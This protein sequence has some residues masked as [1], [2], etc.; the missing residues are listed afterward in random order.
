MPGYRAQAETPP[1]APIL[2]AVIQTGLE[3]AAG[4]DFVV[5]HNTTDQPVDVTGYKLQYRAATATGAAAWTTKRTIACV[6]AVV[7]C[8]VHL[9]P[10]TNLVLA[11]YDIPGIERHPL[12]SGFSDVGGQVRLV[13]PGA[14]VGQVEVLD[15]VGYGNAAESEGSPAAAPPVGQ[16]IARKQ[17]AEYA[18]V[19]TQNNINDF[20][21]G[22]YTVA[23]ADVPATVSCAAPPTEE[24]EG[25][26]PPVT[27]EPEAPPTTAEPEQPLTYLPLLI[28]ELLPDPES[29]ATDS[30]DEFIE[31]HNPNTQP[32]SAKG[33]VLQAGTEFRY[34][35][36]LGDVTIPAGGYAVVYSAES[37]LSLSNGGTSVRL[38]DPNGIILDTITSYGQAKSGQA[39]AKGP[40]GWQWTLAPTPGTTNTVKTEMPKS[41]LAA[42]AVAAKKATTAKKASTAA[43]KAAKTTAAKA[44]KTT[45]STAAGTQAGG[46]KAQESGTLQYW[47][48]G[49]IG[50]LILGYAVYEY[51]Q[52]IARFGRKLWGKMSRKKPAQDQ[53]V[54][55][56][57]AAPTLQTD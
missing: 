56:Q 3:G 38:V 46:A 47:V 13:R 52:S 48:L 40:N 26:S 53:A 30:A 54:S 12:T 8:A 55:A 19:D 37:H 10:R 7:G 29:P 1:T 41:V 23:I 42:A 16:V 25:E 34:Q 50:A 17:T 39:W 31:I 57:N 11:T 4:N 27:T 21:A 15:M 2:I 5:L 32:V 36:S 51:R 20:Q 49:G 28:S 14:S 33:Y 35:Y 18:L 22:C 45:A 24:P 44:T 9:A 6:T 43:P